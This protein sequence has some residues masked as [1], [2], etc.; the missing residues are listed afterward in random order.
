MAEKTTP[1]KTPKPLSFKL[2]FFFGIGDCGF[3]LMTN[4]ETFYFQF[5]LTN[6]AAFTTDVLWI[7]TTVVSVVDASL[8]WIYGGILNI[9]KP[10]KTGRY[11]PYLIMIPWI[12]PVLFAFQFLKISENVGLSAFVITAAAI[13]SHVIWNLPYAANMAMIS[14]A[15]QTI[16]GKAVLSSSRATWNSIAAIAFSYVGLPL[17]TLISTLS[18]FGE[19]VEVVNKA[20]QAVTVYRTGAFGAV[21]FILGIAMALTYWVHY[22][23]TKGYEM[24][25]DSTKPKESK[26]KA[27]FSS[28]AK[29]LFTNSHLMFLIVADLA[30]WIVKFVVAGSAIYYWQYVAGNTAL[31]TKYVLISGISAVVGAY[32]ARFFAKWFTNKMAIVYAYT[33]MAAAML[34]AYFSYSQTTL[35]FVLMCV[36]QFGYGICYAIAPALYADA[37]VYADWKTKKSNVGWIMGLQTLPLKI[38]VILKAV[39][40]AAVLTAIGFSKDMVVTEGTKQGLT[41]SFALIP[42]LF[43][44]LGIILLLFGYRLTKEKVAKYQA[45]LDAQK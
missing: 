9:I 37:A 4:I 30:K 36:G 5:F 33:L 23:I 12:V 2:K 6:I 24:P 1:A 43:L 29:A 42:A 28:M 25:E 40:I 22:I 8:S 38:G 17:I 26:T 7:V 13:L 31:Q 19:K 32:A 35:V 15:G 39:V 41:A 14:I 10:R 20:T 34:I 45:E 27:S 3:S 11:R 44:V 21:A 16:Q 18:F